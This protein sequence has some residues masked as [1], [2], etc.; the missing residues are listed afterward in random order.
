MSYLV[1]RSGFAPELIIDLLETMPEVF[2]DPLIVSEFA[3]SSTSRVNYVAFDRA[4]FEPVAV[5]LVSTDG[6][7]TSELT[8]IAVRPDHQRKSI[9]TQL[10][11]RI[12]QD[13]VTDRVATLVLA[14]TAFDQFP[15]MTEFCAAT[16]FVTGVKEGFVVRAVTP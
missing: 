13:L 15:G 5:A 4:L 7:D 2:A 14:D 6:G 12:D 1:D 8:L 3:A 10:L 11:A 9:A 16:G